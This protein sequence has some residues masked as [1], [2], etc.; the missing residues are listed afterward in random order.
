[1][2]LLLD[3]LKKAAEKKARKSQQDNNAHSEETQVTEPVTRGAEF[4]STEQTLSFE[5]STQTIP[6]PDQ[7]ADSN[8]LKTPGSGDATELD[9]TDLDHTHL[10]ATDIDVTGIEQTHL[11]ATELD[12][13]E[14]DA[15]ELDRTHIDST[16][17]DATDIEVTH[18]EATELDATEL[19]GTH[20]DSTQVDATDIEATHL[21]A[22]EL[23]ATELDGT[24]IDSTQVDATDI[25][26]THLEATELDA[27]ELDGTH[28]DSTQVDATHVDAT[29]EIDPT[30]L[31]E[32]HAPSIALDVTELDATEVEKTH[33]DATELDSTQLERTHLDATEL[34]ATDIDALEQQPPHELTASSIENTDLIQPLTGIADAS[35]KGIEDTDS[36]QIISPRDMDRT[37]TL[38]NPQQA[39]DGADEQMDETDLDLFADENTQTRLPQIPAAAAQTESGTETLEMKPVKYLHELADAEASAGLAQDDADEF[40]LEPLTLDDV[41]EFMGDGI[42]NDPAPVK[43]ASAP[44]QPVDPDDTTITNSDSLSLTNFGYEQD[45]EQV[46]DD[47]ATSLSQTR[48]AD[49]QSIPGYEDESISFAPGFADDDR[50]TSVRSDATGTGTVDIEKLTNDETVT[51]KD[52]TGTR[53]FAPDNYDRTLLKLADRDVSRIFAG[54]KPDKNAVMTPDYA[55]KVFINKSQTAR[56]RYY[57]YYIGL[58]VIVLAVV[59]L[60]GM[61]QIQQESDLIDSS[62][63]RLRH[64]PLP[65]DIK[66]RLPGGSNEAPV[67]TESPIDSRAVEIIASAGDLSVLSNEADAT[68]T[69]VTDELSLSVIEQAR[70]ASARAAGSDV[71]SSA[72]S[73]G[74]VNSQAGGTDRVENRPVKPQ[75][76][77]ISQAPRR[78][79]Q[80]RAQAGAAK[81]HSSPSPQNLSITTSSGIAEEDRLLGEAYSAYESGNFERA[82]ELYASVTALKPANRDA[83]LG[84]AAIQVRNGEIQQAI[85]N[86]RKVLLDNPKDSMALASLM[87]VVNVDPA[88]GETE[89]K[90]LLSEQPASPYLHFVLGNM[91]GSQQRWQE[92]QTSYFEALRFKPDDPN[93]AYNLA[94]SL[95]H[96]EKPRVAATF[97]QRALDNLA[98]GTALAVFDRNLVSQ[99]IQVLQR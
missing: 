60:W 49:T 73:S 89:I 86:Y 98:S 39:L 37:R 61:D 33:L 29:M 52:S 63:V 53:T 78:D 42:H 87:S 79:S 56:R 64:D 88:T 38:T 51:L 10:D 81:P 45:G 80:A 21:E 83:L 97:Y 48:G 75:A 54:M 5:E 59:L 85:E 28:I 24:H 46:N 1:M 9:V 13:T 74:M 8:R 43:T 72:D 23:D 62:L 92:A 47:G 99:R 91:Y 15:T 30:A 50:S 90:K 44:R 32:T 40:D 65:G 57:R 55:K 94:V 82:G 66:H 22:A 7:F 58:G 76:S 95:E 67:T 34:D 11:D 41:T 68:A 84:L 20:I 69:A 18:L 77:G 25:E 19:D 27:T 71:E 96:I 2:S 35:S 16:Q 36:I 12:S 6:V 26:A 4:D 70:E 93:Y 3:A 14:L 31:A 17:V